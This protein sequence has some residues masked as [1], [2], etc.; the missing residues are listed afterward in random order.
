MILISHRGNLSGKDELRENSLEYVQ[1]ALDKGY[2]VEV[3]CW[4][5]NNKI[6]FGHDYPQYEIDENFLNINKQ[7]LWIH[8]KNLECLKFITESPNEYIG[9]WHE[10]DKYTITTN[11]YIWTYPGENVTS[12]S[13]IVDLELKNKY[14]NIYGICTDYVSMI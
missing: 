13:I 11:K 1:E 10:S 14:N 4:Y 2:S 9:F 8:C 12:R 5:I 7:K 3:D 6:Y